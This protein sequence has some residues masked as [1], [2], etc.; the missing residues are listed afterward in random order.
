MKPS[1]R[2]NAHR[3]SNRLA[4]ESSPYLLQHAHNP[5]D[6]YGWGEEAFARARAEDRPILLSVGYSACHW[7]HVM[8]R[9]SFENEAIAAQMNRDFVNVKVD[10]EERPDVDAIYMSAVQMLTGQGGWPM[11][12]F[13]T[14][15]G[16]P[17]FGGTYFP[18]HD[19]YG[20]PGFPRVLEA[21]TTAWR[22]QRA[23]IETQGQELLQSLDRGNDLT[24]GL[25]D[26]LLTP[27]V[28]ENAYNALSGQFDRQYGGFGT[29]P[30]FPQPANL[31]FLL[32]FHARS[33]RQEPLAMVEKTLQR[34]ALGG[35]YDQLG[36]GFHRYST[37]QVWLAP[38]FEKM[39]YDNAQL[40]QTYARCYQA[41][42]K[43]FYRGVAEETLEYVLREMTGPEGGFYS[44]QDADSEGEEG[45]FFVWTP[46]E[47][48]SVLGERD[49]AVFCAFYDV[50]PG[51]NWE[52][53]SILRVVMDAPEV[54]SRFGI[55]VKEAAEILDGGRVRLLQAREARVKPGLDDKVLTAWN[56]LMLAAFAECA[57]IF[58][59]DDFR[60]AAIKNAEFLFANLTDADDGGRTRLLRTWRG[61]QAKLNGYL[62]DYAFYADGLL[63]LY[64]ATF[65][66]HWLHIARDLVRTMI[67]H[68]WDDRDGGFYATSDDH[69]RLIQRPKDWDDNATPSGNS[70]A[71]ELLLKLAVI[72]G[73]EDYRQRAARVLRKIGPVLEK[74]PYGF[75]RMLGA[76][77]FYLSAPK[78]IA[79][80]GEADDPATQALARAVFAPY[81]P[82][83]VLVQASRPDLAPTDI[84]LLIDRPLRDGKP[85][86]YVCENYAC[87]EPTTDPEALTRLLR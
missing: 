9:E 77:D 28:L 45:K 20:R 6:W 57:A 34:M 70:V 55:T 78:E 25:P 27:T 4:Q 67:A 8:E 38:H 64:E 7:C 58:D 86:A 30:K 60:Q 16:T 48:K 39:L 29:A 12:V 13:L 26:S 87:K 36:G 66:T 47:I 54:A 11:T 33:R 3:H 61:G 10:R 18:P 56:G 17:F 68:F 19:L 15:D 1:E 2:E 5:V 85:T 83:R 73:E 46:A 74:H 43:S 63:H 52:S 41:T 76:L 42:G 14:P 72:T 37:D 80:I 35:I 59:R 50:S 49:A 21:V 69:E 44:A 82:N 24:H 22:Q 62:E 81:L 31:D 75:A 40:A 65:D 51:G 53:K 84:P 79:L 71:V 23:E 32:R